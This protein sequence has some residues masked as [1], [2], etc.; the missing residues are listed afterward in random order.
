MQGY[1]DTLLFIVK[2]SN[3]MGHFSRHIRK[4]SLDIAFDE[5][6]ISNLKSY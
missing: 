3:F 1:T 6:K 4:Y 2:F 5:Q